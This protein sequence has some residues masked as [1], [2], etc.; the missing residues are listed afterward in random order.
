MSA[1]MLRLAPIFLRSFLFILAIY[2]LKFICEKLTHVA[3]KKCETLKN[4]KN[5]KNFGFWVNF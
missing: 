4:Q 5:L 1:K 2:V 3:K